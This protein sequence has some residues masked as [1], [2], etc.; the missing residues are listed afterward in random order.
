MNMQESVSF[1]KTYI[2]IL[3]VAPSLVPITKQNMLNMQEFLFCFKTYV[4]VL[5]VMPIAEIIAQ[6]FPNIFYLEKKKKQYT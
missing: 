3:H 1:Y 6:N 5:R 4:T 2:I